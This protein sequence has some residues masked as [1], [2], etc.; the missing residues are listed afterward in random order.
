VT[1]SVALA[2]FNGGRFIREQLES[3]AAQTLAPFEL[4]VSDDGSTDDTCELV[5]EFEGDAPFPVRLHRN[6][7]R[8]GVAS[9]F[10]R[11]AS[12]CSGD[13]VAFADQDDVWLAEKLERVAAVDEPGMRLCV[14]ACAV[15]D[16]ALHPLGRIVPNIRRSRVVPGLEVPKWAEAPGMGMV[17]ER[18]L[19]DLAPWERRPSA[20]HSHGRLLHDEWVLGLARV[21]GLIAFL[22]E[23]LCLYRQHDENVEGAPQRGVGSRFSEAASVGTG[24]YASRA[25]QARD[26]ASLLVEIPGAEAE[27]ASYGRLAAALELRAAAHSPEHGRRQRLAA[28]A[29]GLRRGAYAS[30]R[31]EGFGLR[32]FA[33]DALFAAAGR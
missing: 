7:E 28:V 19:L 13:Q 15:V 27:A 22:A 26:W 14:H 33:R 12:L 21:S 2:S 29:T 1:V 20:H 18:A 30:R 25:E 24:Y 4:V 3:I 17:F 6:L 31:G 11:A 16:D 9:N 10:M 5:E 23:P 8:L 32:G